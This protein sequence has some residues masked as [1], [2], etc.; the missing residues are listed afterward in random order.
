QTTPAQAEAGGRLRL[1]GS[2]PD[3]S[4]G[5]AQAFLAWLAATERRWLVVLD[6]IS[7]PAAADAWWAGRNP[8]H[9]R[10]PGTTPGA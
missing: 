7:D 10:G 9:R 3:D 5:A 8:R 6:D 1:P 2:T 4:A